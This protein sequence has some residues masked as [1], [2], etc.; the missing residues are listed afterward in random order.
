MKDFQLFHITCKG[1]IFYK[2]RFLLHRANDPDFFGALECPGGRVNEGEHIEET[3]KRELLEEIGL[4]LDSTK[5]TSELFALN[6]REAIEYDWDGKITVIELYYKIIIPDNVDFQIEALEEVSTFEW[7]DQETNL[8]AYPYRVE[9][10]KAIY[11][12]AQNSLGNK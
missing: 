2:G 1:L 6:Q 3:L 4:N 10:R 8:D 12:K 9:S 11:K 7:I 5:H